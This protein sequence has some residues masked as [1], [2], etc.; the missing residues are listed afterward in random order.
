MLKLYTCYKCCF[1]FKADDQALP[2]R[3][4]ACNCGPEWYL[5]EPYNKEEKRR[6]H[7]DPPEPDDTE[8]DP[9]DISYH[10]AKRFP[11]RS[12]NGRLRRFVFQYSDVE[13]V[14]KDYTELLD[15]DIIECS[16]TDAEHPTLFCATGPGSP[17]W[18][19]SVP[20]FIYGFFKDKATD[21][22]E[23]APFFMI[24]VDNIEESV[25]KVL[26]YGGKL[27]KPR[28]AESGNEYA[29]IEDSEGNGVYLWETP[30][31]VTWE[32]PESQGG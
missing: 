29:I 30:K 22:T 8:R 16:E 9:L 19:P 24:E 15:W 13:K 18:E 21:E 3:C 11:V 2:P 17:N 31:T 25:K 4:P 20:S 7:V 32:E 10:V 14:K 5:G 6:I 12:R 23:K 28:Y 26:Q 27:L 1:P